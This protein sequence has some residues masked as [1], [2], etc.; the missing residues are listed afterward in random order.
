MTEDSQLGE[1]KAKKRWRRK[2]KRNGWPKTFSI[3]QRREK[4]SKAA[5][6]RRKS[7]S[8]GEKRSERQ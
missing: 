1:R 3:N 4:P 7:I 8:A 2:S 6:W 5:A